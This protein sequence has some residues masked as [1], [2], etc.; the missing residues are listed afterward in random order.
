MKKIINEEP[1][2]FEEE[3][4]KKQWKEPMIEEH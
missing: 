1:T 4:Q 2:T 3:D